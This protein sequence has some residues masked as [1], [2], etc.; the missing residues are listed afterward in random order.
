MLEASGLSHLVGTPGLNPWQF[1]VFWKWMSK[2]G[3]SALT[4]RRQQ[5][6]ANKSLREVGGN[7]WKPTQR[8]RAVSE[9]LQTVFLVGGPKFP[10]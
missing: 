10:S 5:R 1:L 6:E 9:A 4:S 8:E 3:S 2:D 7:E